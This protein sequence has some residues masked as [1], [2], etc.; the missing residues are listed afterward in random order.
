MP[1]D[2]T[3]LPFSSFSGVG[4]GADSCS[5]FG[6]P[7]IL[8]R[9]GEPVARMNFESWVFVL[10]HDGTV[11]STIAA[12][13]RLGHLCSGSEKRSLDDVGDRNHETYDM[14]VG[15]TSQR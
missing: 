5:G 11:S 14:F 6:L 7:D 8:L 1:T 3:E 9:A 12:I 15:F 2:P 4:V 10:Y 13:S